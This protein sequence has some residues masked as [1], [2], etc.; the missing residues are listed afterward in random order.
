MIVFA[1]VVPHSPLLAPSVGKEKR[2]ALKATLA[3]Y[4]ELEHALYLAKAET[5]AIISPHAASYPDAMSANMSP[6]YVGTLKAFG[7]HQTTVEA[8][9]DFL[10]LDRMQR[11]LRAEGVPFTLTSSEELDYGFTIPLLLLTAHLK[12]WRLLPLA[13]SLL[14]AQA[15]V[16]FGKQLNSVLHRESARVAVIASADLSH[17]LHEKSP[18]GASVEGPAFDAT[19]RSKLASLDLQGLLALDAQAVEAAGQCGYR[20]IMTLAGALDG[21][22]VTPK[23]LAYEAP[24]GVGYLTMRFDLA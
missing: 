11:E 2:D 19:M 18:G 24:F 22:N 21:M 3:A 5:L 9:G 8:K 23:E 15:H 12:D 17:K 16:N 6:K 13:P 20:P 1:A 14:P 4:E 10:L 7:D